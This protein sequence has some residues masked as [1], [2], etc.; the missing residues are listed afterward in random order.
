MPSPAHN[1]RGGRSVLG[2]FLGVLTGTAI[3]SAF[4]AIETDRWNW[5]VVG[6]WAAVVAASVVGALQIYYLSRSLATTATSN[7]LLRTE[8]EWERNHREQVLRETALGNQLVQEQFSRDDEE[9]LR[10]IRGGVQTPNLNHIKQWAIDGK[11]PRRTFPRLRGFIDV[12]RNS[13]LRQH[14]DGG[15]GFAPRPNTTN[16]IDQLIHADEW[17]EDL[18]AVGE[19]MFDGKSVEDGPRGGRLEQ[20]ADQISSR[21]AELMKLLPE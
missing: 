13:H 9:T 6:A 1:R 11:I 12:F 16:E 17:K 18:L 14:Q 15:V 2:Y 4:V 19:V 3:C 8:I 7:D 10:A 20:R 5:G 21:L